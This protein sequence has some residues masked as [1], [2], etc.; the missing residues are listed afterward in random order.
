MRRRR[1]LQTMTLLPVAPAAAQYASQ[2]ANSEEMPKL[3]E[4]TADAAAQGRTRQFTPVQAATLRN[5][6]DILVPR[7]SDRPGANDAGAVEF[8]DFLLSQSAFDRQM[9]YLNGLNALNS[10]AQKRFGRP[11]ARLTA[12]E[13]KPLLEPLTRPWTYNIPADPQEHFLRE[14]KEDLLQATANSRPFAEA[15][16][17]RSRAAGGMGA[18]WLPLD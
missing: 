12:S 1:L 16:S 7:A 13:A 4:T 11:F 18:Y 8:L 15:M 10:E 2:N 3:R 5:L 17:K 9:R 14:A 6:A